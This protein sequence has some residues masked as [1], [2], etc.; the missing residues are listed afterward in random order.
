MILKKG[1]DWWLRSMD[2]LDANISKSLKQLMGVPCSFV[3]LFFSVAGILLVSVIP[4]AAIL[5]S[6]FYWL[7]KLVLKW[8]ADFITF[9]IKFYRR[10]VEAN[11]LPTEMGKIH[12]SGE[13]VRTKR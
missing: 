5:V 9:G 3:R 6:I 10:L 4:I 12:D 7:L 13:F 2:F 1:L 8:M 11:R